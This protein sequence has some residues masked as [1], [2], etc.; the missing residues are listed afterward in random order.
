PAR[1]TVVQPRRW[2][3]RPPGH[4]YWPAQPNPGGARRTINSNSASSRH[5]PYPAWGAGGDVASP[6]IRAG[7]LVRLA[8]RRGGARHPDAV[9]MRQLITHTQIDAATKLPFGLRAVRS[10]PHRSRGALVPESGR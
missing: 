8:A 7:A 6:S 4:N 10:N 9:F 2:I 3:E 5:R 1:P